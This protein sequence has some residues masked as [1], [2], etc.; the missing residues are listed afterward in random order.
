MFVVVF[1]FHA[2]CQAFHHNYLLFK[3]S[4]KTSK[5][6]WRGYSDHCHMTRERMHMICLTVMH[7][8][9]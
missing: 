9:N 5:H 3:V 8:V 7:S 6:Q 2:V 4:R 1:Q